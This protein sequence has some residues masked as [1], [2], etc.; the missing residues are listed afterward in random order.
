MNQKFFLF[1]CIFLIGLIIGSLIGGYLSF[2]T[3]LDKTF[4]RIDLSQIEIISEEEFNNM[5]NKLPSIDYTDYIKTSDGMGSV[6]YKNNQ[7]VRV[8]IFYK[9]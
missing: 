9:K 6:S 4:E 2:P 5:L 8:Q 1:F 7:I 3:T